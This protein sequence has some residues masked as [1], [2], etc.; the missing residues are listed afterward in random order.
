MTSVQHA[1]ERAPSGKTYRHRSEVRDGIPTAP[2]ARRIQAI[3]RPSGGVSG[4]PAVR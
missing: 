4:R 3:L 1:R 2:V